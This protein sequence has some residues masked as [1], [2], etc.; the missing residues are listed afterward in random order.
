MKRKLSLAALILMAALA[1]YS[2]AAWWMLRGAGAY[3]MGTSMGSIL[4][5][6]WQ[7]TALAALL[8][9][10]VL[11]I[12]RLL[13]LLRRRPG[14]VQ[15]Q[16][17]PVQAR[18]RSGLLKKKKGAAPAAQSG[19]VSPAAG[20]VPMAQGGKIPPAAG[21]V[22]MP[23]GDKIPPAGGTVPM[24]QEPS[25]LSAADT[26]PMSQ[27]DKISPAG[28]TVPMPQ[29]PPAPPVGPAPRVCP[30]CGT[31]YEDGQAFCAQCGT[32]LKGG[33]P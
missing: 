14:A 10:L 26:V 21:T 5:G 4:A 11:A 18:E 8:L 23:Q 13:R 30:G 29:E 27:G 25:A 19:K 22:P 7:Y 31:P 15:A 28:G 16:N 3:R 6:S 32:A 2:A 20:T 9:F 17:Q 24:P 12:P 1:V 33:R